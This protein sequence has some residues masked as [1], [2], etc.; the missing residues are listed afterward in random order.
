ME[1]KMEAL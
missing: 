1:A